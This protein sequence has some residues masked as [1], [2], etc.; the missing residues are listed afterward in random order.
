AKVDSHQSLPVVETPLDE[1]EAVDFTPFRALAHM[2]WA[3]TAH[4]VY[5]ALDRDRPATTSGQ[6]VGEVIRQK[7][8]FDGI[9]LTDDLSMKA[10]KGD[11][12]TR[13]AASLGAGCDLVLHCNGKMEEME[14]A[15]SGCGEMT[16]Q[17]RERLGRGE[18]M[19]RDPAD[20]DPEGARRRLMDIMENG[21]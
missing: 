5:T 13:A 20:T 7:I 17:T 3:M 2:P 9:L 19:R 21:T 15:A 10:L 8:G 14:A 6:V 4:V 11:Y 12:R 1:L 16:A 18:A